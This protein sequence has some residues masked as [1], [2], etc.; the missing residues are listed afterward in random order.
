MLSYLSTGK[1][2]E[3]FPGEGRGAW[4]SHNRE[5]IEE[6]YSNPKGDYRFTCNGFENLF[7]L[8][9]RT[10]TKKGYRVQNSALPIRFV[11]GSDDAVLGGEAQFKEAVEFMRKVGYENVTSKLYPGLRHEIFHDTDKE[12]VLADLLDFANA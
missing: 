1:G 8:M 4:L 12:K 2:N 6:F 10:Y 5:N 3:N 7:K 11:S 9:K